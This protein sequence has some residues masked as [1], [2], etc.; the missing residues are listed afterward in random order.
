PELD[1]WLTDAA[2]TSDRAG[3][4]RVYLWLDDDE[5]ILGYFAVAPHAFRRDDLPSSV[6]RGSPTVIRGCLLARLAL[7]ESLHGR[8]MGGELLI[9]AL[10][11]M[12]DAMRI[13]GGRI[14]VVDAI[15]ERAEAFYQH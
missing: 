8:G 5:T 4:A 7:S 3:T 2:L 14:I 1:V 10:P 9:H 13:G 12:L 11:T 15:D 6:G